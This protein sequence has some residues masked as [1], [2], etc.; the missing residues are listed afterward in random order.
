[1]AK[2][3]LL[4]GVSQYEAG[5]PP[6]AAA[7]KDV[8][9]MQ[10]VLQDSE[11]GAFDEVK[12]L[13]DP[14]LEKMQTAIDL[15]FQSCQ[16]GDLG[17][18]YFSG[19]GITDD[20]DR[21]YLATR[22]TS[23]DT[24]RS[25]AVSASFIQGIMRDHS[26][27]RQHVLILDCC[28]S[29]A[30]A[31]GWLAKSADINLK[32]QLEVEGSVVLTSSTSTQ[33]S[34]EDKEGELS[35]YTNYIVQG[36][37]SGAAESDG[38]GMISADELHEYAKRHV[39]S[40]KPA[41]KP[42]IY[43]IRQ[44]I[45]ICLAKARVDAKLE[46]RRLV[47]R[48]AENGEISFVG[49]DILEVQ[50]ERWGLSDGVAIAIENEV[51]EPVRQRFKNLERY[52]RTLEKAVKYQF[53][54]SKNVSDELKDLQEVLGLRDEDVTPIL[55]RVITPYATNK[56]QRQSVIKG[57]VAVSK[58]K[59]AQEIKKQS[60]SNIKKK[61]VVQIEQPKKELSDP[62]EFLFRLSRREF[63][64]T[65]AGLS[66]ISV[67]AFAATRGK[68][69]TPETAITQSPSASTSP[70]ASP[71]I[72]KESPTTL[73]TSTTSQTSSPSSIDTPKSSTPSPSPID[74]PKLSSPSQP[75]DFT[76][77]LGKNVNLDMVYIPGGKFTMGSPPEEK[78]NEDERPQIKDVNVSAFYM[79]KYEV[80]QAQWQAIMETNPSSFKNNPQN[81]VETVTWDDAQEFCKKISQKTGQEFRLPSEAEWE[82][83]CRAGTTTA[84]SFGDSDSL[85]GKYAVY[86]RN[87]SSKP[88][89]VG[90]NRE[91]NPWGLYD[92]HGNVW[93]WCQ[94]RYEK[95]G[96]ESDLIRRTGKPVTTTNNNKFRLRVLRGGSWSNSARD[97]RSASRFSHDAHLSW[98]NPIGFRVVCVLL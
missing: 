80:T 98:F 6:L 91:P 25:T 35:L 21:L 45:K 19:H 82:Y 8:A 33:K 24:F 41:M 76:V 87:S 88:N 2:K 42:E 44:G 64:T 65:I 69:S 13:I 56:A 79:G 39:Q 96:G 50:R 83:A 28:Y 29:G 46:Y 58:L 78:G 75:Q 17:L 66:G 63:I 5:L 11:L 70:I 37:E 84:Y 90:Q 86:E 74:T 38:D 49:Q 61:S 94:D 3:A 81:P 34:Y 57:L 71:T 26:Y 15:L 20:S 31:E 72:I 53:P 97:C 18:L 27:Q 1:M 67:V 7:P 62:S 12:T 54:L 95:Y 55:E 22:R 77:D 68:P 4:I 36:I 23:K 51:L 40:A 48:Y 10:R 73:P 9:A 43:G 14:D 85:L 16:K 59:A 89:P 52:H 92:M 60:E 32:P 47:E 30:F 93:E